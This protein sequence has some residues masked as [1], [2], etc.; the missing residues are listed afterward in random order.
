M[1]PALEIRMVWE[2]LALAMAM[3]AGAKKGMITKDHLPT[4]DSGVPGALGTLER[5][6][7]PLELRNEQELARCISNQLQRI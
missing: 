1:E 4:G 7:N 3:W 5:L 6:H 2:N